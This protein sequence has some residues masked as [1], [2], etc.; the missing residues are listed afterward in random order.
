MK[1]IHGV[2]PPASRSLQSVIAGCAILVLSGCGGGSSSGGEPVN[3]GGANGS[4]ST[5]SSSMATAQSA[6]PTIA[7]TAQTEPTPAIALRVTGLTKVSETRVGRTL[8][9]F[10][11]KVNVRNT[12]SSAY[13]NVVLTLTAAGAGAT[14]IDG[15]VALGSIASGAELSPSD[16]VTIRQDRAQVFD[17]TALAWRIEGTIGTS[18]QAK[19]A[20]LEASG[21]IPKLER[22]N[23]LQGIDVNAN[24]VRDDVD[25]F[26]NNQY[27]VPSQRA[28]ALQTAQ[29]LQAALLVNQQDIG[30]AKEASRRVSNAVNCVFSQFSGGLNSKEP[31]RVVKELEGVTANTKPRLLA[32]LAYNKTLNGTSSALPEGDTCE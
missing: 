4:A 2:A 11:F 25:A 7:V 16:T 21:A 13:Q 20:E 14:V 26:I 28:A 18:P 27:P 15:L 9:D 22:G 3:P 6:G 23:T 32:Y 29:A 17:P 8:F 19:L 30:A 1:K 10:T 24:G 31:A 5:L 12:G